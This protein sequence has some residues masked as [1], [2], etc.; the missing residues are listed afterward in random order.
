MSPREVMKKAISDK[1]YFYIL[2]CA[3]NFPIRPKYVLHLYV[4]F[5]MYNNSSQYL[6]PKGTKNNFCAMKFDRILFVC[7]QYKLRS[8]DIFTSL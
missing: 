8:L 4:F 7:S 5:I 3:H 6:H 2:P 1:R